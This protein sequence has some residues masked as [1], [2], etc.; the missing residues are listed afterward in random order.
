MKKYLFLLIFTSIL[1]A[2][3]VDTLDPF[4]EM[5]RQEFNVPGAS[6]SIV[7]GEK[8]LMA[9]G[10]GKRSIDNP[11]VVDEQT[12]FQLASVSKTFTATALA[13]QVQ[14]KKMQWDDQVVKHLPQFFL[15][16]LYATRFSNAKDLLAHRTGLPA[17]GGD[18]LGKLGYTNEEI[19]RRIRYIKPSTSFRDKAQY[20][21][22]GYFLAGELLAAVSGMSWE[23]TI[24]ETLLTP[25]KM[26]RSGFA[27]HIKGDNISA[28]HAII[29]NQIQTIP[30]DVT[31]GF[32]A[33]GAVTSTAADMAKWMSLF[34]TKSL[35]DK[36]I[37]EQ[38]FT[39]AMVSEIE[40]SEAPPFLKIQDLISLLGGIAIIIKDIKL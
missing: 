9:K 10:Y 30:A 24:Q 5:K 17:F 35:L 7:Q 4:I 15:E 26:T 37:I 11:A 27:S 25:L 22:I 33:A 8:V 18:L 31:G 2:D 29:N 6:V 28:A 23:E 12:V 40:F 38:I 1:S 3:L 32:P 14:Q 13:L 20:S 19:L 36:D 21:N 34:L 39:P 16:D